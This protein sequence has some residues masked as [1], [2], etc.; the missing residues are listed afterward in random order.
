MDES[1]QVP[2][3]PLWPS[4]WAWHPCWWWALAF[5]L[6]LGLFLLAGPRVRGLLANTFLLILG[7]LVIS[8]PLGTLLAILLTKTNMAGRKWL[9]RL[10]IS[11]LLVPLYVQAAAWQAALGWGG[12]VPA[13]LATIH[14]SHPGQMVWLTGWRGAIWV[15]A[16]AAVPWVALL[17][18]VA[19]RGIERELEED[20]LM[21][22]SAG[23]VIWR[24]TLRQA[25]AGVTLAC[26]WVVTVCA[27]EMTVTDLFQIRSIAEEVYTVASLGGLTGAGTDG[28]SAEASYFAQAGSWWSWVAMLG[29]LAAT[30]MVTLGRRFISEESGSSP[31]R[32][33]LGRGRWLLTGLGW[34]LAALLAGVPL[35]SMAWKAGTLVERE[36]DQYV[37]SWSALKLAHEVAV[38]PVKHRR[39]WGW[40]ILL[41]SSAAVAA[42]TG[43]ILLAWALRKR[44]LPVVPTAFLVALGFGLP[45]PV[46]GVW[47]IRC[48][49]WPYDSPFGFLTWCYDETLLAPFLAQTIRALPLVTFLLWL[50]MESVSQDLLDSAASE[51]AGSWSQLVR[52][53]LPLRWLGVLAALCVAFIIALGELA[54]TVLVVPP[55]V[56]TL[57][58]RIFGLLHYGA[59]DQM[60]ALCLAIWLL[61]SL[62][63]IGAVTLLRGRGI[64]DV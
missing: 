41:G 14:S 3:R 35:A 38:S 13:W 32:W 64:Y 44:W 22:G 15:H 4:G 20:A 17:V 61:T 52:L 39:E 11:L 27:G 9:A 47:L 26:L 63:T 5:L 48:L 19:L 60:A 2:N 34:L 53:V 7:T 36:G 43:G 6:E 10:L 54:A 24:V 50:Q 58:I 42:T 21:H 56:S 37:R 18:A 55:G 16:M 30:A 8:L 1:R 28:Q 62:L 45:G 31:W 25:L 59:E 51:G 12:W 33:R 46:L 23:Q 49:N 40:S 29:V 57:S